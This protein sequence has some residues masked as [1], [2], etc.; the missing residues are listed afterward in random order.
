MAKE[1]TAAD[2]NGKKIQIIF[3][4]VILGLKAR[5]FVI[6]IPLSSLWHESFYGISAASQMSALFRDFLDD[7]SKVDQTG[8]IYKNQRLSGSSGRS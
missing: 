5:W 4:K 1:I 8:I 6:N 2:S 7:V 3:S